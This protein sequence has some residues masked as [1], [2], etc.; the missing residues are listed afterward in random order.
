MTRVSGRAVDNGG[1]GGAMPP[2]NFEGALKFSRKRVIK[3]LF[4]GSKISKFSR[5]ARFTIV[6]MVLEEQ[7]S[8]YTPTDILFLL[9]TVKFDF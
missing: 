5:E 9:F 1:A 3:S 8:G 7:S 4:S 2:Q 6:S